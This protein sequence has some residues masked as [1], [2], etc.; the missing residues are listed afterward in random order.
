MQVIKRHAKINI[1]ASWIFKQNNNPKKV[2]LTKYQLL[3]QNL[4]SLR[5]YF[6]KE[7]HK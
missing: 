2:K 3:T 5:Y 4:V 1:W 7:E 6:Q